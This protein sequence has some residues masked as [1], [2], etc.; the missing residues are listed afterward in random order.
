MLQVLACSFCLVWITTSQCDKVLASSLI[1]LFENILHFALLEPYKYMSW[2]VNQCKIKP[3]Q[4]QSL[5]LTKKCPKFLFQ[6]L[7][8]VFSG[9]KVPNTDQKWSTVTSCANGLPD[10]ELLSKFA[11]MF[12]FTFNVNKCLN[13]LRA[14]LLTQHLPEVWFQVRCIS[15]EMH[16]LNWDWTWFCNFEDIFLEF[17]I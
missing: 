15:N 3:K 4:R 5:K 8:N 13:N 2:T 9:F 1:D 14:K 7:L 10:R 16:C 17:L 12:A 6:T 11:N